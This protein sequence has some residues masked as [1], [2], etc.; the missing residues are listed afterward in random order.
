MDEQIK[1]YTVVVYNL[2]MCM[3]WISSREWGIP[4]CGLTP[5]C[6]SYGLGLT[7][8]HRPSVVRGVSMLAEN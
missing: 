3:K 5:H 6:S 4:F 2:W 7:I 8:L 1:L